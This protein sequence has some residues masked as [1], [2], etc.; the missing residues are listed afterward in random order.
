MKGFHVRN[1]VEQFK[2]TAG[3]VSFR[4]QNSTGFVMS[5]KLE[6]VHNL[7]DVQN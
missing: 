2:V 6:V 3:R 7:M 1:V 5:I 4:M